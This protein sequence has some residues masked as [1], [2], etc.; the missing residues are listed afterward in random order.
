MADFV[1]ANY[2][3]DSLPPALFIHG[4]ADTTVAYEPAMEFEAIYAEAGNDSEFHLIPG[5]D[6][7]FREPMQRA[8]VHEFF[9]GYLAQ[10]GYSNP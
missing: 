5:A 9:S 1:P 8:Q 10:I 7:F 4:D 3:L 6:H 2:P